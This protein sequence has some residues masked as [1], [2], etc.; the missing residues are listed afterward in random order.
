[1][2]AFQQAIATQYMIVTLPEH[3]YAVLAQDLLDMKIEINR[4][5]E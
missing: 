3:A 1:M 4:H 5:T 2:I